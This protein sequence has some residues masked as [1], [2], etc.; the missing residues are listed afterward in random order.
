MHTHFSENNFS[1]PGMCP[2]PAFGWLWVRASFKNSD[3]EQV[4]SSQQGHCEKGCVIHG[5]GQEITAIVGQL[6]KF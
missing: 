3:V 4:C 2:K 5:D 1:K 6:Q